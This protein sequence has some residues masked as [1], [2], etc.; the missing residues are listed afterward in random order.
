MNDVLSP[1]FAVFLCEKFGMDLFE[2]ENNSGEVE[3]VVEIEGLTDVEA[4]SF[5]VFSALLERTNRKMLKNFAGIH[6][7]LNIFGELV[8]LCSPKLA[9]HFQRNQLELIHFAFRWVFCLLIREF[10][11]Y[12]SI[13]LL[14]YFY[15]ST[16]NPQ[17]ICLYFGL[18][19]L[20]MFE[21][22]LLKMDRDKMLLF[23]QKL[24][25]DDW[26][27]DDLET[28]Y[29]EAQSLRNILGPIMIAES[30]EYREYFFGGN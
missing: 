7:L 27:F 3:Q 18:I 8:G 23:L 10:P 30:R 28:M 20:L 21:K 16:E 14:G 2:L 25:T 13:K 5:Y 29:M 17:E 9:R 11:F 6:M 26:G 1:I 19:F 22:Q 4:D 24:P 12:L 15:V